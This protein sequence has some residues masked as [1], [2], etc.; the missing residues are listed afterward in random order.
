[1]NAFN[2]KIFHS[3]T[4]KTYLHLNAL[5]LLGIP[6]RNDASVAAGFGLVT[7]KRLISLIFVKFILHF[8]F[9]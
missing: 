6:T 1:M 8:I 5:D 2:I 4:E 9:R 3:N 7:T